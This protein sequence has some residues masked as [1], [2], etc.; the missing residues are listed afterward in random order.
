MKKPFKRTFDILFSNGAKT[1]VVGCV[2]PLYGIPVYVELGSI[3]NLRRLQRLTRKAIHEAERLSGT[4]MELDTIRS[5]Q[6]S[7]LEKLVKEK[8][9]TEEAPSPADD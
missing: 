1:S 4:L 8:G 9:L 3:R 7:H 6:Q 5:N 2:V